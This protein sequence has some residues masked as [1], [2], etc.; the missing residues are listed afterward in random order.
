ML[1]QHRLKCEVAKQGFHQHWRTN[2]VAP[3]CRLKIIK[4]SGV[5]TGVLPLYEVCL[6]TLH[7]WVLSELRSF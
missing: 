2:L 5:Q 6:H 4:R 1:L 3:P 7:R